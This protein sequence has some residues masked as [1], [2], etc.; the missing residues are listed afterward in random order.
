MTQWKSLNNIVLAKTEQKLSKQIEIKWKFQNV[1]NNF[2]ENSYF[3]SD[4]YH[5]S[6]NGLNNLKNLLN[7]Y[8][9]YKRMVSNIVTRDIL[10]NKIALPAIVGAPKK[11]INK[12]KYLTCLHN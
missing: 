11:V 12:Y 2:T 7:G 9:L 10:Q 5:L 3:T 8:F 6:K 4:S 1:G